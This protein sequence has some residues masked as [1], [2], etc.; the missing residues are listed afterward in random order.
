MCLTRRSATPGGKPRGDEQVDET[1]GDTGYL[2]RRLLAHCER[3][4]EI[5]EQVL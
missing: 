4:A 3:A 2:I 5:I 1:E